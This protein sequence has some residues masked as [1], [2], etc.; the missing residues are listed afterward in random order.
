MGLGPG[1]WEGPLG[2]GPG[3]GAPGP[4]PKIWCTLA[5]S[6]SFDLI[7]YRG[8]GTIEKFK[9]V[10]GTVWVFF[11][12]YDLREHIKREMNR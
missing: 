3:P 12:R 11:E 7:L 8:N 4:G 5:E 1:P 2:Q 6:I 10:S 9:H